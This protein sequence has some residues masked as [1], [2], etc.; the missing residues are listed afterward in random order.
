MIFTMDHQTIKSITRTLKLISKLRNNLFNSRTPQ[1]VILMYHGIST[2]PRYNCV[3]QDNFKEQLTWLK[4]NYVFVPLSELVN[5]LHFTSQ[6]NLKLISIT[7]DDGF[8]NFAELALPILKE[9]QCHA[10]VFIPSGK[11]GQYNDWDEQD[12]RFCKMHIMTFDQIRRLPADLVE[13]GSHGISHTPLNRLTHQEIAKE[14]IESR[15]EIEQQIGRPVRFFAFPFGIYPFG[16][17]LHFYE[18]VKRFLSD[19]QAAC[20]TWWGRYNSFRDIYALRRIGVWDSDSLQ[21]FI[22]KLNGDYD[23]LC[24]KEKI[25]RVYKFFM[26]S[27]TTN[28]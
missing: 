12:S 19:Y 7:F 25:G 14:I 22:D 27:F 6:N 24:I 28:S 8:V 21:D 13:I 23:W 16:R 10:T 4:E 17:M 1:R 2:K 26:P 3:T 9:F 5:N 11:A 20:T 18:Y 15:H